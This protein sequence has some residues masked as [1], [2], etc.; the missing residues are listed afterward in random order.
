MLSSALVV[1]PTRVAS[2]PPTVVESV[3]TSPIMGIS[4]KS[5]LIASVFSLMLVSRPS[6]YDSMAVSYASSASKSGS[7]DN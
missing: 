6:F 3:S 2:N 1:K 4:S 5:K 7:N